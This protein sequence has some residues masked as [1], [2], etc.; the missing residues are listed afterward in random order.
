MGIFILVA[1]ILELICRQYCCKR[2]ESDDDV[3]EIVY[4]RLSEERKLDLDN[5]RSS[6]ILHKLS[7][8]TVTVS[9]EN[10]LQRQTD[11]S[12]TTSSTGDETSSTGNADNDS[13]ETD[14]REQSNIEIRHTL[15]AKM[16][17]NILM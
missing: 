1:C 2:D 13:K 6:A 16:I 5:L 3:V 8:Y 7:R 12:D 11:D 17:Q 4:E 14:N 9:V 15:V 10:M